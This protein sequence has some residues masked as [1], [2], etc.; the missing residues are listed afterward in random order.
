MNTGVGSIPLGRLRGIL[1]G[2]HWSTIVAVIVIG[3]VVAMSVLP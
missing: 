3:Q 1:V 2:A